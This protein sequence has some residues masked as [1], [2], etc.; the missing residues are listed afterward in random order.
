MYDV[1]ISSDSR[2]WIT[3]GFSMQLDDAHELAGLF[4]ADGL[5]VALWGPTFGGFGRFTASAS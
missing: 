5:E 1:Q 4:S 3:V 2:T